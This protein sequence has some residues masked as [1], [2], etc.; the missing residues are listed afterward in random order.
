MTRLASR[1]PG[2]ASHIQV[3]IDSMV[4]WIHARPGVVDSVT[5]AAHVD[6]A[7]NGQLFVITP[8]P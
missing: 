8:D 6:G 5:V 4:H 2:L 3:Q 1:A 7:W